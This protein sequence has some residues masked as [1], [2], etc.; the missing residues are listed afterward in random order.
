M[1]LMRTIGLTLY[2]QFRVHGDE[3][4]VGEDALDL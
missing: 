1:S 3:L 4:A 2:S